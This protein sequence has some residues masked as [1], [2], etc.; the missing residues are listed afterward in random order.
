MLI[1]LKIPSRIYKIN[2]MALLILALYLSFALTL[3][4][5]LTVPPPMRSIVEPE[6]SSL[7]TAN[8]K[9]T[10][11]NIFKYSIEI[12]NNNDIRQKGPIIIN[13]WIENAENGK[14]T[15]MSE[16][17]LHYPNQRWFNTTVDLSDFAKSLSNNR[18][19]LQK[20]KYKV[21]SPS[22]KGT[23][24]EG[25]G[26]DIWANFR[27]ERAEHEKEKYNYSI[28]VI[29]SKS[30]LRIYLLTRRTSSDSWILSDPLDY[31]VYNSTGIWKTLFW[32][33][34]QYYY[35]AR[36]IPEFGLKIK[37]VAIKF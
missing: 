26:P 13:L 29:S 32:K 19:M 35:E 33:G 12:G 20:L 16:N 9:E 15:K 21:C 3:A 31:R 8:N 14:W 23:I 7:Y 4:S 17:E 34:K 27:N 10:D 37:N 11:E 18:S 1:S 22:V 25:S 2:A 36:F 6:N 30:N 24:F 5:A 28:E